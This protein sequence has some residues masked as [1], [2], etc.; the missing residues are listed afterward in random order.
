MA[1]MT[2]EEAVKIIKVDLRRMLVLADDIVFTSN[3]KY[4]DVGTAQL[5][6]LAND[7]SGIAGWIYLNGETKEAKP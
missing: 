1:K 3:P 2:I 4:K 5:L 7:V 6:E